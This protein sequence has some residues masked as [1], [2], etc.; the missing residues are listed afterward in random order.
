MPAGVSMRFCV[1]SK[2]VRWCAC[3][4]EGETGPRAAASPRAGGSLCGLLAA[5]LRTRV[6][7]QHVALGE[8]LEHPVGR[9]CEAK[10]GGAD[11][12]VMFYVPWLA[13]HLPAPAGGEPFGTPGRAC[14]RGAV[15]NGGGKKGCGGRSARGLP[16]IS[17]R[18]RPP[19]AQRH[20]LR[21]LCHVASARVDGRVL[22]FD[23]SQ[24][25][26]AAAA[27]DDCA[28]CFQEP[29]GGGGM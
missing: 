6:V 7:D 22:G 16:G 9:G 15:S 12:L 4:A 11:A 26:L 25:R 1:G 21:R 2:C 3:G 5:P 18:R 10:G 20:A 8:L 24:Q 23:V 19:V 27:Y 14:P 13:H 29:G 17:P 28:A